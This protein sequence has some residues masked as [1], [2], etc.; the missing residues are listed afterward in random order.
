MYSVSSVKLQV[1]EF[2]EAGQRMEYDFYLRGE[3]PSKEKKYDD[4][5]L[6]GSETKRRNNV[7]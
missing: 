6:P 4:R 5:A 7:N 1:R 2:Q 3:E